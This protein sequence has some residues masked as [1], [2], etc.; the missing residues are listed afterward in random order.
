MLCTMPTHNSTGG[1]WVGKA[2]ISCR[3]PSL[4]S[5]A[6][7]TCDVGAVRQ[8]EPRAGNPLMQHPLGVTAGPSGCPLGT[9]TGPHLLISL[10]PPPTYRTLLAGST[11]ACRIIN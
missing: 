4:Q 2:W 7:E 1:A 8:Q 6:G 9:N 5:D 3:L 11:P 10:F